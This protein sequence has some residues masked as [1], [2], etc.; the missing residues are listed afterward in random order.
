MGYPQGW[1]S[2]VPGITHHSAAK[3]YGN[4]VVPLQGAHAFAH[5]LDVLDGSNDVLSA[6]PL[7][8]G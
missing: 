3:L 5:L 8:V 2:A 7:E 4:G 6:I 1:I